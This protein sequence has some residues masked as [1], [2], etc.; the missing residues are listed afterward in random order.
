[1]SP[2][3]KF[4]IAQRDFILSTFKNFLHLIR[5]IFPTWNFFDQVGD[6]VELRFK[7]SEQMTWQTYNW[8][9]ALKPWSLFSNASHN[10]R[11]AHYNVLEHFVSDLQTFDKDVE[12]LTTYKLLRSFLVLDLLQRWPDTLKIQF[13]IRILQNGQKSELFSSPW[14]DKESL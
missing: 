5:V 9:R 4:A 7:L 13:Q 11:L 10:L 8:E 14:I 3:L 1:M 2:W 6:A 12:T